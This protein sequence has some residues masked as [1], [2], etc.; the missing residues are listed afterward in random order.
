MCGA[1]APDDPRP[2]DWGRTGLRVQ[3]HRHTAKTDLSNLPG[4]ACGKG[5]RWESEWGL[6]GQFFIE[7]LQFIIEKI[8][9]ALHNL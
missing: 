1:G 4:K 3:H 7:L 9:A 5:A 8:V 6:D 2:V